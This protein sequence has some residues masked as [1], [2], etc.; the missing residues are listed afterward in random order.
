MSHVETACAAWIK[1][2]GVDCI[3]A[4]DRAALEAALTAALAAE[5]DDQADARRYRYMMERDNIDNP[6]PIIAEAKNIAAERGLVINE[7]TIFSKA[8]WD[9]A[10]DRV[11]VQAG[12]L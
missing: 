9:E 6:L 12:R 10:I 4:N 3:S 8:L 5:Q 7:K 2:H 1:Y 11:M